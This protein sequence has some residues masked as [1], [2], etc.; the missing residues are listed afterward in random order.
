MRGGTLAAAMLDRAACE[1]RVY[2]LATLLS[3]APGAAVRVIEAVI[4]AQPDLRRLDS[5]HMD[6][7]TVLRSREIAAATLVDERIPPAAAE[8]LAALTAQ[9]REAWVLA[10][11]YR[12][13][14]REVARAMDCSINAIALHLEQAEAAMHAALGGEIGPAA[15][16]LLGYSMGLDVPA[17]Y[18]ARRRRRRRLRFV[19][20]LLL[21]LL[22][23]VLLGMLAWWIATGLLDASA[24]NAPLAARRTQL[25]EAMRSPPERD[26]GPPP[27]ATAAS[28]T[29]AA[30]A[31]MVAD[32]G[33]RRVAA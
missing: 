12:L 27:A 5:A 17:F 7:L 3:G 26:G 25:A 21:V 19:G 33:H 9:Q 20:R 16:A 31:I 1:R 24:Q 22:V 13:Q 30:S 11:V 2:R 23:A 8:A 18:R 4:D 32:S 28:M 14:R 29:A 10:R 15:E 6:R